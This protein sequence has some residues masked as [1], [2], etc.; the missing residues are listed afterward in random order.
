MVLG[1]GESFDM[2]FFLFSWGRGIG[3]REE[4]EIEEIRERTM[5]KKMKS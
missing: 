4:K 5:T 1:G 2:Y 3:G